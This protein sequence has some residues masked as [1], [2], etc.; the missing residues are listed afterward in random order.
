MAGQNIINNFLKTCLNVFKLFLKIK[1]A[2]KKGKNKTTCSQIKQTI[3]LIKNIKLFII[4][5]SNFLALK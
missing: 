3:G 5:L 2:T 4:L 1:T